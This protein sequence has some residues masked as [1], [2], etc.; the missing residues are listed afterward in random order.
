VFR[1][2]EE[3]TTPWYRSTEDQKE[4]QKPD[5]TPSVVHGW[6]MGYAP[7]DHPQIAFCVLV[8]YAGAGGG[9][10]AGPVVSHILEACVRAGYLHAN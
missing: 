5:Q 3:T 7:V 10:S 6:Y 9:V 4:I 1:N 8:E 2:G